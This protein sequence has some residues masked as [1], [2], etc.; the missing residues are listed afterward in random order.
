MGEN[1]GNTDMK[2]FFEIKAKL[3]GITGKSESVEKLGQKRSRYFGRRCRV[4]SQ[5]RA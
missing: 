5:M 1:I 2:L 3:A 4:L